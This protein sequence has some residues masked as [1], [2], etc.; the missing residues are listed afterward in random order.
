M[1]SFHEII[2]VNI[3]MGVGVGVGVV[4]NVGKSEHRME[5]DTILKYSYA[6]NVFQSM[7]ETARS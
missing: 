2:Y 7:D 6:Y 3:Y 5:L 1:I 4:C